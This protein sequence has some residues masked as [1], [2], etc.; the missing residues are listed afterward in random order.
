MILCYQAKMPKRDVTFTYEQIKNY[1]LFLPLFW[2][3]LFIL[4]SISID[5]RIL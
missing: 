4:L 1:L 2:L 3:T 5:E